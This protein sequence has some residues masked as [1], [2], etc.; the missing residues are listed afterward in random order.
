MLTIS[1]ALNYWIALFLPRISKCASPRE[2]QSPSRLVAEQEI[3][4]FKATLRPPHTRK[5]YGIFFWVERARYV[6]LDLRFLTGQSAF[7]HL[8]FCFEH[9]TELTWTSR[10]VRRQVMFPF[11]LRFANIWIEARRSEVYFSSGV[12]IGLYRL[13]RYYITAGKPKRFQSTLIWFSCPKFVPAPQCPF[14][15]E[16][17]G[18]TLDSVGFDA[19]YVQFCPSFFLI[20]PLFLWLIITH[21]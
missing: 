10:V 4:S 1:Q 12:S 17:I 6:P 11:W 19:V 7:S 20:A 13:R 16:Y 5:Q 15:D 8:Q 2:R 18:D 3:S 9:R 21:R 14:P